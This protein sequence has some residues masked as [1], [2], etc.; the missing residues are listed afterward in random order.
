MESYH[1]AGLALDL[2]LTAF[3]AFILYRLARFLFRYAGVV[4][5]VLFLPL[6]LYGARRA[7]DRYGHLEWFYEMES[8]WKQAV[9]AISSDASPGVSP[10]V[11]PEVSSKEPIESLGER[12]LG[13]D[14]GIM[15][16]DLLSAESLAFYALG[17]LIGTVLFFTLH[18][19]PP[20]RRIRHGPAGRRSPPGVT[21]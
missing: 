10:E 2:A 1:V 8:Q 4:V 21:A 20:H 17:F 19:L 18:W 9:G 15:A 14:P 3:V 13:F 6:M 16:T 12:I 5:L 11:S 7:L